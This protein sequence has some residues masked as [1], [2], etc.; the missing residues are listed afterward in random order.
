MRDFSKADDAEP[1]SWCQPP[2]FMIGQ[3]SCGHWVVQ[4]LSGRR[5][6]LFVDRAQAVRYVR[7]ENGNRPHAFVAISG[8]FELDMNRNSGVATPQLI[9]A[10]PA[11]RVA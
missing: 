8:V 6:G 9:D 11:R 1:P 7:F 3:D 5:G 2:V 4:D 10:N